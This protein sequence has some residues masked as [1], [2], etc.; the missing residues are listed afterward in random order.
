MIYPYSVHLSAVASPGWYTTFLRQGNIPDDET[1]ESKT[2]QWQFP[3]PS[4]SIALFREQVRYILAW[5]R[6]PHN[7]H[8]L[9]GHSMST[10]D[11]NANANANTGKPATTMAPT[12]LPH[13]HP[14]PG[15]LHASSGQHRICSRAR[16]SL[17]HSH[18]IKGRDPLW[19]IAT[20]A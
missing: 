15:S 18:E 5:V 12:T 19:A 11:A 4:L 3:P 16:G 2:P 17:T 1:H 7:W 10:V 8:P 13:P 6:G 14:R 9:S 20:T